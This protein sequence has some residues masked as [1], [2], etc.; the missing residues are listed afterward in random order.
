MNLLEVA[1]ENGVVL[2]D[3]QIGVAVATGEWPWAKPQEKTS[4]NGQMPGTG[5]A[6]MTARDMTIQYYNTSQSPG[7]YT[8][9][10]IDLNG[11]KNSS[12]DKT[13]S[14]SGTNTISVYP[15]PASVSFALK[16]NDESG[17][18]AVVSITN[19]AGIKVMEFQTENFNNELLKEVPVNSLNEGIYIVKV[20]LDNKNLY[21]TKIV[22][23]K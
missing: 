2:S 1:I 12:V 18:T 7:V 16:L 10:T 13:I 11:C 5:K 20:L 14:M 9:E 21:Y 4:S 3:E 23:I 17:G 8:V 6:P 22:I 19:S 15:N